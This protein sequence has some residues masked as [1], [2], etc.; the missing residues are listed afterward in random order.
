LPAGQ[1]VELADPCRRPLPGDVDPPGDQGEA[2]DPVE[3][4]AAA[5]HLQQ[6]QL[7]GEPVAVGDGPPHQGDLAAVGAPGVPEG[8]TRLGEREGQEPLAAAGQVQD[9]QPVRGL[10]M[11]GAAW[12]PSGETVRVWPVVL[13]TLV[14]GPPPNGTR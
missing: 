2:V 5:G 12:T 8:L 11:P 1:G 14:A 13:V 4:I 3:Q 6:A 7:G 9:D 10:G